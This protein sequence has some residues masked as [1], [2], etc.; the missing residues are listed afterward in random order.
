MKRFLLVLMTLAVMSWL[1]ACGDQSQNAA[2]P[3]STGQSREKLV[4]PEELISRQEAETLLGV[5]FRECDKTE[6]P[7]VGQIICFYDSTDSDRLFQVA[8][9]QNAAFTDEMLQYQNAA[10][11][12]ATTREMLLDMATAES[13]GDDAFI[14]VPGIHILK[15]N[16]Y[17]TIAVGNTSD[18]AN[19]AI[20]RKAG[21]IAVENLEKV[22][23]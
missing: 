1:P 14:A 7:A 4:Q 3:A 15:G 23:R 20:L 8:L 2:A 21:K 16:H 11:I 18:E 5:R 12:Y 6:Q 22:L 13:V 9:V 19:R 10:T 17:L